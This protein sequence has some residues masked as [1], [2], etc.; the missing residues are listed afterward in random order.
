MICD[1]LR[2]WFRL[3]VEFFHF[4]DKDVHT[5]S[6]C[7]S[8]TKQIL[9]FGDVALAGAFLKPEEFAAEKKYPLSLEFCES[10]YL[11][12]VPQKI[13]PDVLFREYFYHS[14]AIE[15]IKDH[16][17]RLAHEIAE[18]NP[19]R[20]VE[21]GCNDGVLLKPLS[22]LGVKSIGVDPSMVAGE[23]NDPNI[24]VINECFGIGVVDGKADV[25]VA[26]NVFAHIADIKSATQ[27]VKDL[28]DDNGI[29]M[30][31]VNRLDSMISFLQYDWIY[32]EHLY[33][34]SLLTLQKHFA[35]YGLEVFDCK[36]LAN[37]AG[38][39]RYYVGHKG[40]HDVKRSVDKQVEREKWQRLDSIDTFRRFAEKA[41]AHREEMIEVIDGWDGV[42]AGYGACGR[43]NTMLQ[44]CGLGKDDI[45]YI[46]DDAPAK[47]GFYTP[48]THIPVVPRDKL[49]AD[50]LIVFA[51]SFL[52]EIE[53]KCGNMD[54]VVPLPHIYTHKRR[55][56]ALTAAT[57]LE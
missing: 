3:C 43:T 47:Q 28:L 45:A 2:T 54:L 31:E 20:V 46:V 42:V 25:I 23:I 30:F 7:G 5:C 48:G 37:H 50:H 44:W 55:I 29:F 24:T 34:Y 41:H 9:D 1:K 13:P 14:S 39:M 57:L 38:S 18:M 15:T 16:S 27:A 32:H 33:Y 49:Y 53:K 26:N 22:E 6:F 11:L 10:C 12:Q 19:R 36:R 56:D 52:Q 35:K 8:P 21:I 40:A 4:K 51:W 17:V